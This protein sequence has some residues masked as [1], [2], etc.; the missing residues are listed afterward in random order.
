[1]SL[2]THTKR[3]TKGLAARRRALFLISK[4][5]DEKRA[6][7]SILDQ[8][9]KDS[10]VPKDA[11]LAR[12]IASTVLRRKG[13][14]DRVLAKR[15]Q[16]P[17]GKRGG[18]AMNILR[19]GT[20]Q[21]LFMDVADY[22]AVSLAMALAK[23]DPRARHFAKL[24][25][26]VLRGIAREKEAILSDLKA[27]DILPDWVLQSWRDAYGTARCEAMARELAHEP[28][29]DLSI[30]PMSPDERDTLAD[31]LGGLALPSGGIRL[32]ASG[33]VTA[34]T[35]FDDGLWWVQDMAA[36][37]APALF[38][39]VEGRRIADLCAA[40]GGKTA[41]LAARGAHVTAVDISAQRME[42]LHENLE[43]L[44]LAAET[45]IAD[46]LEWTPQQPFD[47][48]LLDAPCSATGTA[49][50]HP[51]VL[52]LKQP[53]QVAALAKLQRTLIAHCSSFLK[54]G[55]TLVFCTC[56]LEVEEGE[57]I[58][59]FVRTQSLPLRLK[60]V[61]ADEVFGLAEIVQSN[62]TVRTLPCHSPLAGDAML[63][64]E[65][66]EPDA[67]MTGLDGFFIARF[68]KL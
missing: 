1:M 45:E 27:C 34:L 12:A 44:G 13:Q 32:K 55:G 52:W 56:S 59:E 15:M 46:L 51:D 62:G 47:H 68:E 39:D 21:I 20:A 64:P 9:G 42:R 28:Y 24:I 67:V 38:G 26:G 36:G 61:T 35:G 22:A 11:A 40:P 5:L 48:I 8:P 4:V 17:L 29:L 66:N 10:L 25:N 43:R 16:K 6:L 65:G 14:V 63:P 57:A 50:K 37:L 58:L 18:P 41:H 33:A 23:A 60:P 30:K 31:Q 53:E 19:L 2:N 54:P 7:E 3:E 49:R